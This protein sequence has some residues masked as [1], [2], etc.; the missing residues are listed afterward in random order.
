[1]LGICVC[2]WGKN[3]KDQFLIVDSIF[4]NLIAFIMHCSNRIF[5]S[6]VKFFDKIASLS[7]CK[8]LN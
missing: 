8:I 2:P 5:K 6:E 4:V 7:G 3:L 1:M